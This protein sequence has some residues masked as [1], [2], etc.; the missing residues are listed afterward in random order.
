MV[1]TRDYAGGFGVAV[2]STRRN[3]GHWQWAIPYVS[4]MYSAGSLTSQDY[5]VEYIDAQAEGLNAETTIARIR[6]SIP[7]IIVAVVNLPSIKGDAHLLRRVKKECPDSKLIC[8]GTVCKV[9]PR[10]LAEMDFADAIVLG[11]AEN[12][13]PKLTQNILDNGDMERTDGIGIVD[14][15]ELQRTNES[16]EVLDLESLPW[17]PYAI[18]PTAK[19]YD[20][21]FGLKTNCL[22][23]WASRGC[24][25]PCS[26]YCP[27]PVGLGRRY[28]I[29]PS[30]DFVDEIEHLNREHGISAFIFRDQIFSS[31]S[32]RAEEICEMLIDRRLRIQW[33]CETRFDMVNQKLLKK[34]K[35]AGCK[36]L[37]FGLET[38][39]PGLLQKI[40]KPGMK[41]STVK[42]AVRLTKKA[43][44]MPLTH[45]IVGLPGETRETIQNTMRTLREIGVANVNVNIATPYPGTPLHKYASERNLLETTNWSEYSSFQSIMRTESLSTEELEEFRTSISEDLLGT[46]LRETFFY[47]CKSRGIIDYA[48]TILTYIRQKPSLPLQFLKSYPF[49]GNLRKTRQSLME[50]L[51]DSPRK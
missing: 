33:V 17:P 20:M 46:N 47:L 9:L 43:G 38:G 14:R 39:D 6:Q 35:K 34:M 36:R 50:S 27:Y 25:M 12:V 5:D 37:H 40:G 41:L 49:S 18:M 42:E 22:P 24:P 3:Y 28:R 2:P 48:K 29:R 10:E 26:F 30:G 8:I 16:R 31:R 19:Y 13:V 11:E 44:I 51:R 15:G 1:V 7:K 21:M 32:D 23:V 45:I 4:L